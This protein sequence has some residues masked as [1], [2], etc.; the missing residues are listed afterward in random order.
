M[1]AISDCGGAVHVIAPG[2]SFRIIGAADRA[3]VIMLLPLVDPDTG[4]RVRVDLTGRLDMRVAQAA[5]N[6]IWQWLA[7]AAENG[8]HGYLDMRAVIASI[9]EEAE[10]D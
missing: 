2:A 3:A 9:P 10:D 5:L 1:L 7:G 4:R 6:D 8:G